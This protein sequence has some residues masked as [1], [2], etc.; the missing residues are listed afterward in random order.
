MSSL[1]SILSVSPMR[2]SFVGG[3]SDLPEYYRAHGGLAVGAGI[4]TYNIVQLVT[5]IPSA[6]AW[7][8]CS[9][10]KGPVTGHQGGAEITSAVLKYFQLSAL[11]CQSHCDLVELGSGLGSS[12]S[13]TVATV[14]AAMQYHGQQTDPYLIAEKAFDIERNSVGAPVGKQD[15]YMSAFGGLN[16][17]EFLSEGTVNVT[18]VRLSSSAI[19]ELEAWLLLVRI[20]RTI[21][22]NTI[23]LEHSQQLAHSARTLHSQHA[24]KMLVD[25]F[26]TLL[27]N[28][29]FPAAANLLNRVWLE[30]QRLSNNIASPVIAGIYS[31]ALSAG[32]MGGKL[33][34]AGGG[35][36]ML[37]MI[38]PEQK[39][40]VRLALSDYATTDIRFDAYGTRILHAS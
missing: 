40:A 31:L 27:E 23:L 15:H 20:P 19:Q 6:V 10:R 39:S 2:V 36:H 13:L 17:Y 16:V 38:P 21:S 11:A 34:G 30:K 33:L 22:A 24:I 9:T 18:P 35:G 28:S 3:G 1:N 29:D 7:R 4:Q 32:A 12:S 26:V 5:T 8:S 14:A 37:L 25:P